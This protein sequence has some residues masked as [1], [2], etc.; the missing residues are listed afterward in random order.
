MIV[1]F[2][3]LRFLLLLP[4]SLCI[5]LQVE[6][7]L[8]LMM[9]DIQYEKEIDVIKKLYTKMLSCFFLYYFCE[10]TILQPVKKSQRKRNRSF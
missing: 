10:W 4:I 7:I 3:L 2:L 9:I 6:N 1:S 5:V 8:N